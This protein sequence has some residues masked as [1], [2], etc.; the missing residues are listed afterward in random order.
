[1]VFEMFR[2]VD[3][4]PTRRFSGVGLG[5]HIAKRLVELL[6]GTIRVQSTAAVG[7]TFTVTIPLHRPPASLVQDEPRRTAQ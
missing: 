4:S 7:S 1:M 5:L 3:S 6:G 2:Q